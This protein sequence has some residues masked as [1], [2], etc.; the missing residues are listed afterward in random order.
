MV[1]YALGKIYRIEAING[2]E[3]EIYFGSTTKKLLSQRMGGHR[4]DYKRFKEGKSTNYMT[5]FLIFDKYGIENCHIVL[6]ESVNATSKD[7]LIAREQHYIKSYECVNK[8]VAGRKLAGYHI[9]NKDD[10]AKRKAKYY[11]DNKVEILKQKAIY[12]EEHKEQ[13]KIYDTANREHIK[14]MKQDWHANKKKLNLPSPLI[15]S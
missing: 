10:I 12:H 8:V 5:S 4:A 13:R 15:V 2:T 1:N 7:E 6:L 9:D 3:E 11:V 14:K